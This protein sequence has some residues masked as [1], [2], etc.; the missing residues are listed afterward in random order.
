MTDNSLHNAQNLAQA[1]KD[2]LDSKKAE[3]IEVIDVA[4]KGYLSQFVV[5][6]CYGRKTC[7][8]FIA[9]S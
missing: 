3:S 1:V 4:N 8:I 9:L 7:T 2:I 5:V 6:D